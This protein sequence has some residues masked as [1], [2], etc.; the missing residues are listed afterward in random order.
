MPSE[1]FI[2]GNNYWLGDRLVCTNLSV[3]RTLL[4]SE[5]KQKNDSIYQNPNE[6]YPPFEF[7]FF[8]ARMRHYSTVQYHVGIEDEVSTFLFYRLHLKFIF[9][10]IQAVML[11]AISI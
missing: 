5:E 1:G 6:E 7:R 10:M 3:N 4:I 11:L 8:I 2:N 9:P